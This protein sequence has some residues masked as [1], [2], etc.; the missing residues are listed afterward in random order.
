MVYLIFNLLTRS[1]EKLFY[2][3]KS[4]IYEINSKLAQLLK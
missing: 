3:L 2:R 1:L 4:M